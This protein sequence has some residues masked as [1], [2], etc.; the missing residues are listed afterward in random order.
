MAPP[1][2][3]SKL[4]PSIARQL[5]PFAIVH[6]KLLPYKSI[7]CN[8]SSG[9]SI[10]F[11][12]RDALVQANP[13][14]ITLYPTHLYTLYP[15]T[16]SKWEDLEIFIDPKTYYFS[17]NEVYIFLAKKDKQ[18]FI[19][20]LARERASGYLYMLSLIKKPKALEAAYIV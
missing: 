9:L 16:P 20:I 7:L 15:T 8:A 19:K 10:Q 3:I 4:P 13:V 17:D 6:R 1:F 2:G 18:G 5:N 12:N 11:L 14:Y